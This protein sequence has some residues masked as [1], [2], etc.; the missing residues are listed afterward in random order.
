[1]YEVNELINSLKDVPAMPNIIVHALNIMK[2]P[3]S[4]T[5]EL[6]KIISYDQSLS[7]KVLTLVNSAY[8]GFSQ[9]ITS[10]S[11]ALALIGLTKAKNII[12]TVAM[13]PMLINHGDKDL[14]KHS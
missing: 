3:E 1:M 10:I 5:K 6:A 2:D 14:W 13:K 11:R 9:Q 12:F 4:S 8:Y 7:T